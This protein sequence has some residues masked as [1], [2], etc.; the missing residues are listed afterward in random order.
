MKIKIFTI[1]LFT[2]VFTTCSDKNASQNTIELVN[3]LEIENHSYSNYKQVIPS[4]LDWTATINF[5]KKEIAAIATW[6]FKNEK[7]VNKIIL[8]VNGLKIEKVEVMGKTIAFTTSPKHEYL[9]SALQ[10]AIG[11]TDSICTI[12]YTIDS[13]AQALQW[14]TP[15]QT[16][17]KKTPYLFTQCEAISARS[18]IPCWDAPSTRITYNAT[19]QAPIGMLALMSATNPTVKNADGKYSFVME[20]P[21][22]TYLIALA[23]GDIEY[24]AINA[25]CGVYAEPSILKNAATELNDIPK[26][27]AAA[28]K[29]AGPYRWGKYDVLVQPPSFPIGG[30]ENPK[31]TFAT[32][33]ILAG[34]KSLVSLIAHELAHSWS[35]NTVTNANWNDLWLNEGFTTYFERR[36]MESITDT[37]YTDMLWELSYQDMQADIKEMGATSLDTR[38]RIDLKGRDPEDGFTNIP[39]EKGAH[40]LWLI[41]RTVGRA[42]FDKVMVQ[43][44]NENAFKPM[45]TKMALQF[46]DDHLFNQN[47]SWKKEIDVD[48]WVFNPGIPAN[49]P[50]PNFTKFYYVDECRNNFLKTHSISKNEKIAA[51]STHEYLQFLRKLPRTISISDMSSLDKTFNFTNTKNSE[52]AFEWYMLSINSHYTNAYNNIE[53]FL[54]RVG[55]KKFV[56]PIYNELINGTNKDKDQYVIAEKAFAKAKLN[57]HPATTKAVEALFVKK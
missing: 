36:I 43:Y 25:Q 13:S 50:R 56:K 2:I 12:T 4:H 32:P 44:F 9:G 11:T 28:E 1:A 30:M 49:C 54:N 15:A 3:G 38:L 14:L 40:F 16:A 46:L 42:N 37:T 55:R 48:A 45:T 19:V 51:W 8:D 6:H 31:L 18:I 41:E 17:G 26:M 7:K 5:D 23:V 34:D 27:I 57:Y 21:I 39:Y 35:G 20:T 24:A 33:T 52:I 10:F 53:L 22:P 29:L 47:S